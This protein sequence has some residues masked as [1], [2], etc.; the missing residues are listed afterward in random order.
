MASGNN[1][2]AIGHG[3]QAAALNDIA[4]GDPA[5]ENVRVGS[6]DLS[7]FANGDINFAAGSGGLA[8]SIG[9]DEV[10]NR[11]TFT[12]GDNVVASIGTDGVRAIDNINDPTPAN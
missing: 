6:Y 10:N 1:S 2:V 11:F 7:M 8:A 9:Y 4:I 5:A 12:I 3:I